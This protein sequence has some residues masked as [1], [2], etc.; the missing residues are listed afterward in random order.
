MWTIVAIIALVFVAGVTFFYIFFVAP[1]ESTDDAF[2]DGDITIV[3]PRISGQVIQLLIQDNQLVKKGDL[4]VEIDPNDYQTQLARAQADL[5][6][7]QSKLA[8]AKVQVEVDQA[9]A[10]QQQA[11]VVVAESQARFAEADLQRYQSVEPRAVAKTTLD[12]QH[13]QA[14]STAA[15]LD[16]ARQQAK[17][18][19]AQVDLSQAT[20]GSAAAAVQQAEAALQQAQLN[21]SYTKI[22]APIDGRV[23]RRTVYTGNY[24]QTGQSL[25]ALVPTNLWVVANFKETQLKNMRPGQPVSIHIDAYPRLE[26]KGKVDSLQAGT[27]E[28]FSLLPPENAVGNYVK[29][30][31]RIPVKILF[32]APLDP[33]LDIA[34][35]LSV[36]PEVKV[37]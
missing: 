25:L 9:K 37:E 23:T 19:E 12:L 35:G 8:Q 18:A 20:I 36:E 22:V 7:A 26:L 16:V 29:V 10:A 5:A 1:Y 11:A 33:S 4:L 3:S 6:S 17:A 13:T 27:G 15:D 30:V 24:I 2:I 14:R 32:D 31:Q 34:P 21:I 28:R